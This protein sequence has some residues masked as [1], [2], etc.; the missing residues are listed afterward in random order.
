MTPTTTIAGPVP[1]HPRLSRLEALIQQD[2]RRK[3]LAIVPLA[4]ALGLA[5]ASQTIWLLPLLAG[6]LLA[7][8]ALRR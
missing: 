6:S 5:A 8:R 3:L 2:R 7:A 4:A 1:S